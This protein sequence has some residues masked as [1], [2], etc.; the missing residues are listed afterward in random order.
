MYKEETPLFFF[1][2]NLF[3]LGRAGSSL[4]LLAA[5]A[6]LVQ[7]TGTGALR[8]QRLWHVG[9]IVAAPKLRRASSVAVAHSLVVPWYVESS[10]IRG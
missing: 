9:S 2:N 5:V 7:G 1:N 6:S 10:R 8:L 3:I 4:L